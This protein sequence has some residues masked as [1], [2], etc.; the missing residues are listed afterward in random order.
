MNR[1]SALRVVLMEVIEMVPNILYIYSTSGTISCR[2]FLP[3]PPCSFLPCLILV[4][5]KPSIYV[6]VFFLMYMDKLVYSNSDS[7]KEEIKEQ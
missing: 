7:N 4:G 5:E 3:M 2:H 1:K 6:T